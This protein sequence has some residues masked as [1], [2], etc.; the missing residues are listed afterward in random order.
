P[1]AELRMQ[2]RVVRAGP[3]HS[4]ARAV[5]PEI[6]DLRVAPWTLRTRCGTEDELTSRICEHLVHGHGD[7]ST[8]I[9]VVTDGTPYRNAGAAD[10]SET[11]CSGAIR[12]PGCAIPE[13]IP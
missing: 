13:D 9:T 11:L 2:Q 5:R 3:S 12:Y 8:E 1:A 10:V 4:L 6:D 7:I